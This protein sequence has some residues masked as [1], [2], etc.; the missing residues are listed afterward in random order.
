MANKDKLLANKVGVEKASTSSVNWSNKLFKD[1]ELLSAR[2]QIRMLD[3]RLRIHAKAGEKQSES[4]FNLEKESSV[5]PSAT[6]YND[7]DGQASRK[8]HHR[9]KLLHHASKCESILFLTHRI[10]VIALP[11][12]MFLGPKIKR[13]KV[14]PRMKTP[15]VEAVNYQMQETH[16]TSPKKE[17]GAATSN[18]KEKA[19]KLIKTGSY[20]A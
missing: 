8:R 15:E 11:T 2:Q 18:E 6:D 13:S 17:N 10:L 16:V 7:I 4:K 9:G 14:L 12:S 5:P 1:G 19:S 20:F 3:G